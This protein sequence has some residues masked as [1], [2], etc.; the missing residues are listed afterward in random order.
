[1]KTFLLL[2]PVVLFIA[3]ASAP[4]QTKP[5]PRATPAKF[6][7]GVPVKAG[8][9][10]IA[11]T[12][13]WEKGDVSGRTYSNSSL[14]FEVTFPDTWLIPG[15]DF[16]AYMKTQGFDLSLKAPDSLPPASKTKVNAALRKVQVLLT[17]YRAMPGTADN[18]IVRISAEDLAANPQIKDAV[19]YLDAVRAMYAT[20]R[21]PPGFKFS[22]TSAEKL[23]SH[24]FGYL[25]TSS[26]EGK[27]RLYVTV[28]KGVAVLFTISYTDAADLE[29]L[30][31]VLSTGNFRLQ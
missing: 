6:P 26:K 25:D 2:A 24:Q 11:K 12:F 3:S 22:E 7:A 23:G 15:D 29:T 27:K 28:K 8:T 21:L 10:P 14:G 19:D 5:R 9:I 13:A 30:R 18:A 16:E 1:M 17:A 31:S 4:S 20:M